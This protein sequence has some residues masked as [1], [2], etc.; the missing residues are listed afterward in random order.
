M[1]G[2]VIRRWFRASAAALLVAA[3]AAAQGTPPDFRAARGAETPPPAFD[4]ARL[5]AGLGTAT[6]RPYP[7]ERLPF[8]SFE[9]VAERAAIEAEV[10]GTGWR[11]ALASYQCVRAAARQ[12]TELRSPDGR[13]IA[14]LRG[15]NLHVRDAA[16]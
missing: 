16:T 10:E 6:G 4:H 9:F 15:H 13:W 2:T 14:F 7:P 8:E 12:P 11:C 3:P 1:K 5:A